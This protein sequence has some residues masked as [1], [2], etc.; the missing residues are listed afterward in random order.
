M[1]EPKQ[2][3]T[4]LEKRAEQLSHRAGTKTSHRSAGD[5]LAGGLHHVGVPAPPQTIASVRVV[6]ELWHCCG[7][8]DRDSHISRGPWRSPMR[9]LSA[10][11][12][13]SVPIRGHRLQRVQECTFGPL[14]RAAQRTYLEKPAAQPGDVVLEQALF[15]QR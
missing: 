11:A 5:L 13:R 7:T 6:G 8:N 2:A 4:R 14:A 3:A 15:S 9:K 12:L 10:A 1:H